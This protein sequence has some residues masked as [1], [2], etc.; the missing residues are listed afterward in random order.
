MT[1]PALPFADLLGIRIVDASPDK[2]TGELI[3]RDDLCTI[4]AVLHGGAAM[5]LADTMVL[6]PRYGK[7]AFQPPRA[8]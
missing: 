8:A 5:A 6:L 3:V 7:R 4:P 2:V 1:L